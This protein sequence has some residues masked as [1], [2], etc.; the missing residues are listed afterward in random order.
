MMSSNR[1]ALIAF[2][3]VLIA[4]CRVWDVLFFLLLFYLQMWIGL[5]GW[6]E[7]QEKAVARM[8]DPE[9]AVLPIVLLIAGACPK[10]LKRFLLR[11]ITNRFVRVAAFRILITIAVISMSPWITAELGYITRGR[12]NW[13]GLLPPLGLTKPVRP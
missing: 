3:R 10:P 9:R 7:D 8:L 13:P 2:R 12:Y 1:R 6:P 5:I 4:F 11:N